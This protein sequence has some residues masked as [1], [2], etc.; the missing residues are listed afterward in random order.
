MAKEKEIKEEPI[1]KIQP[2]NNQNYRKN[3]ETTPKTNNCGFC[4]QQNWS[5]SH[6]CPAKLVECNNWHKMGHF[7]RVCGSKTNNTRKQRINYL[8]ETYSEKEE[9]EQEEIQQNTQINWVLPDKND[10]YRIK[11]KINGKYQNFTIDTG[12]PVTIMPNNLK[13]CD[14][15]DIKPFKERYQDVNK[16][17]IKFLEKIWADIEYNRKATKLPIPI[18]QKNYI[19]PLFCVNWLKQLPITINKISSDEPIKQSESIYTKFNK[20]FE[21]NHTIKNTEVKIQI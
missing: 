17:E 14:P 13:L 1:Q 20:Q 15:K 11:L 6:K 21:T 19:T 16:N 3:T 9:S 4:G 10:N 12:S 7:A 5:P 18:T 2:R 8:E